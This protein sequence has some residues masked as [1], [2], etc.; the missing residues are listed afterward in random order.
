MIKIRVFSDF[1]DS[2]ECK[3]QFERT[4]VSHQVACYG[5]TN[6]YYITDKDDY[7]HAI[8]LNKAMPALSI[9][10]SNVIGLACEPREFLYVTH[11]FVE[12]AK[13]YVRQYFIGNGAGLPFPFVEGF[14]YLWHVNPGREIVQKTKCMSIILSLKTCAPG[15]KYRHDFVSK[16][17]QLGLPIDIYGRGSEQYSYSRVMGKFSET[18]PY[19]D[20]MFTICIEN[21]QNNHY[22]SEKVMTPL[23]FNCTPIYIG[24]PNI[25]NY[26]EGVI[27]M[28][29]QLNS[30]IELVSSILK[31][32]S[33]H[34]CRTYTN[35]NRKTANLLENLDNLFPIEEPKYLVKL[36]P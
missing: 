29:G 23:M 17:I 12:Y 16:I 7:T 33:E 9:P 2:T 6:K 3:K 22:V 5:I 31:N 14:G 19:E 36:T 15:H 20:Y 27:N 26:F 4:N 1:C 30:D 34:Y 35:K 13:K 10:R 25:N 32:P 11:E 8:L 24:C 21:F 28:S 18:E